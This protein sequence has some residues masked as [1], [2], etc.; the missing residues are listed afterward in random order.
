METGSCLQ[1]GMFWSTSWL[2]TLHVLTGTASYLYRVSS[3]MCW[4]SVRVCSAA[5]MQYPVREITTAAHK[6]GQAGLDHIGY[7][8][9]KQYQSLKLQC[10]WATAECITLLSHES[11][12]PFLSHSLHYAGL[13]DEGAKVVADILK[14]MKGLEDL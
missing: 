8:S 11:S 7:N 10:F 9:V 12:S 14:L 5:L 4:C 13:G 6:E 3:H 1:S 2:V